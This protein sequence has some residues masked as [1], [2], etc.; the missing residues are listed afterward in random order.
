MAD[1]IAQADDDRT[2]VEKD[3]DAELA[4][5]AEVTAA[6]DKLTHDKAGNP[7]PIIM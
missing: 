4:R 1:K 7:K 2:Q 6:V 5:Q 3:R